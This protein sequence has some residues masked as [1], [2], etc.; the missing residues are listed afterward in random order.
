MKLIDLMNVMNGGQG[1]CIVHNE[2]TVGEGHLI[3]IWDDEEVEKLWEKE[4]V[5]INAIEGIHY[6]IK[7]IIKVED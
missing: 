3:R 6:D 7:V 2:K 1:V 5:K 4:V